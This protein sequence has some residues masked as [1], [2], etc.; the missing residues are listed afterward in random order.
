[1]DIDAIRIPKELDR[2]FK[3]DDD[4][5]DRIKSLARQGLSERAIAREI[6]TSR[7]TV[8]WTLHPEELK[9]NRELRKNHNHYYDRKYHT[10]HVQ[11]TRQYKRELLSKKLIPHE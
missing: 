4:D 6:P 9:R 1:M 7:T 8:R 5:R 10:K 2:R 3:L 11:S